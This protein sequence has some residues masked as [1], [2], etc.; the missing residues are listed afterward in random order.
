VSAHTLE[1]FLARLYADASARQRFIADPH[2]EAAEAG[3][4]A[5]ERSALENIDWVGLELAAHSFAKKREAQQ[6]F[7][8]RGFLWRWRRGKR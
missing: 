5:E 6:R 1:A 2:A 3:L 8:A 7:A 4:S